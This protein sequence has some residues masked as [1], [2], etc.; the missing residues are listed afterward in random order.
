MVRVVQFPFFIVDYFRIVTNFAR[1]VPRVNAEEKRTGLAYELRNL[2][3]TVNIDNSTESV[4]IN[5]ETR[6]TEILVRRN[7]RYGKSRLINN[8]LMNNFNHDW[9]D[10]S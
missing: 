9:Q 3:E 4:E 6:P 5:I 7:G 8:R 2:P 10:N 1:G